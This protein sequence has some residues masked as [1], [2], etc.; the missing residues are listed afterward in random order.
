MQQD[1]HGSFEAGGAKAFAGFTLISPVEGT[2]VHLVDMK[3]RPVHHWKIPWKLGKH[4]VLLPN[5]NLLCGVMI[6]DGP[7]ASMDGAMGR[8]LEL[9]RESNVVWEHEDLYMHHEFRRLPNGNTMMIRWIQT[10]PSI[11]SKIAGGLPSVNTDG[12]NWSDALIEI[13]SA[14]RVVWEWK[15]FEHLDLEVDHICPLCFRNDWTHA[16]GFDINPAGDIVISFMKTNNIVIIDRE[17]G[18]VEWRWGGFLRLAHP[19][20]VTWIGNNRVLVLG[21]GGHIAG[22]EVGDSEILQI[23]TTTGKILWEFKEVNSTDFYAPAQGGL[24][25]LPNGNVLVCEG[26]KGRLFEVTEAKEIVWEFVSTSYRSSPTRGTSNM[27]FRAYRYGPDYQGLKGD[28]LL[29]DQPQQESKRQPKQNEIS[30]EEKI[31]QDRLSNLGY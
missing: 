19:K 6:S 29:N 25:V 11:A 30:R 18:G 23:D 14:G 12:V 8:L 5:G 7:M 9:D 15:A 24:S 16:S 20:D 26:D 17:K 1:K 31:L 13:D 21:S 4:A 3:G 28:D 10:P 2:E 27:L 22:T